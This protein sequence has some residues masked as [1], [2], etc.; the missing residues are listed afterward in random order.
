MATERIILY[1]VATRRAPGPGRRRPIQ[2][3]LVFCLAL[4]LGL[5]AAFRFSPS[6]D[7]AISGGAAWFLFLL[8]LVALWDWLALATRFDRYLAWLPQHPLPSWLHPLRSSFVMILFFYGII[9][10]HFFWR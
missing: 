7:V 1:R 5:A 9:A 3:V 10:G 2:V 6:I 4:G 8:F